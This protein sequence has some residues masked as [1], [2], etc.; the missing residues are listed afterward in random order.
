MLRVTIFISALMLK[1]CLP[2]PVTYWSPSSDKPSQQEVTVDTKSA[3][4]GAIAPSNAVEISISEVSLLLIAHEGVTEIRLSLPAGFDAKFKSKDVV[5]TSEIIPIVQQVSITRAKSY[6]YISGERY[7]PTDLMEGFSEKV[8]FGTV[9]DTY[10]MYIHHPK[11]SD[12]FSIT[13]PKI[14]INS[15]EYTLPTVN[16]EK[17]F[18]FGIFPIN[19]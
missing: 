12:D 15:I 1:A 6:N 17:S 3:Y 18:G 11:H 8:V 16:F 4:C 5:Y 13:L 10:I 7:E 9:P 14:I 19:C 2:W